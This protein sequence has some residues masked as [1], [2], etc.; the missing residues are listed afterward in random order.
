MSSTRM[1]MRFGR[2]AARVEA[3][4]VIKSTR[5]KNASRAMREIV[6]AHGRLRQAVRPRR[7]G[8]ASAGDVHERAVVVL[9][10]V[11][12]GAEQ[13]PRKAAR[14]VVRVAGERP[15]PQRP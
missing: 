2:S 11:P 4:N 5:A 8:L 9:R 13:D 14:P 10:A 7:S 12:G 3:A 6:I 15:E 1:T